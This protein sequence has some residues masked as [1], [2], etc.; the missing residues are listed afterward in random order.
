M[1]P[2]LNDLVGLTIASQYTLPATFTDAAKRKKI[3]MTALPEALAVRLS[4][5]LP[6]QAG[7]SW[8]RGPWDPV[9]R[10]IPDAKATLQ[11]LPDRLDREIVREVV[12]LNLSR[13]RVL[14]AFVPVHI[15]GWP[16]GLGPSRTRRIL[17]GLRTRENFDAPVDDSVRDRLLEGAER[18]QQSG[19]EEGFRFMNNEGK[20][21]YLG[22]AFFTKWLAYTSMVNSVDGPE[23][24][25][26]LDERVRDWIAAQTA[27]QVDL[28]TTSTPDYRQYLDLLDT[29]GD[30]FGRTRTQVE[31]A[32]FELARDR[33]AEA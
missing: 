16:G 29:W 33:P 18:V 8:N 7:F 6:A 26:I 20:I 1:P 12:Q 10:D 30:A 27:G 28:S 24:A 25:P 5:E 19:A 31:L 15:W 13:D 23:V 9:V 21:K 2:R 4:E 32:I 14:G 11:S 22:G 3:A 17:T